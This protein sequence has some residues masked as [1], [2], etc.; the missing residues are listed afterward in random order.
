MNYELIRY[1]TEGPLAWLSLNRPEKL[2]AINAAM[3][4]ELDHALNRAEADDQVR[5]I[6]LSGEGRAFSAGFDLDTGIAEEGGAAAGQPALRDA[7]REELTRDF[8][9]IMRF[10][11]CPKPTIAAVHTYCLGSAMEMAVACDV[12]IAARDCRLGAPEV[13]FGSGIVALVLPWFCGPKKAKEWLL[14]GNDRISPEQA[15]AWGLVNQVVEAEHLLEAARELAMQ[16]AGNDQLAVRLT[17]QAINRG[18]ETAGMRKALLDALET[19]VEI[20]ST[21]TEESRRF[22]EIMK[23]EG[24][25]AAIAWRARRASIAGSDQ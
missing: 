10:W 8:D 13:K 18:M 7:M 11:D 20:E 22:N 19:D 17:K 4:A 2:N 15:E 12:T 23:A 21:E 25:R 5:V 6:L 16:I 14:T 1:R 9:I 3:I 24:T